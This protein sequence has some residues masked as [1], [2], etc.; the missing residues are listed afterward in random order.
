MCPI[1][2]PS[3][4]LLTHVR[5]WGSPSLR[6]N[7]TRSGGHLLLLLLG[8][9]L[10]RLLIRVI[11]LLRLLRRVSAIVVVGVLV[12][13]DRLLLLLHLVRLLQGGRGTWGRCRLIIGRSVSD[14]S[15]QMRSA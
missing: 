12:P 3:A 13:S 8:I 11:L 15:Y 4:V 2:P 5:I 10:R 1:S 6:Y 7:H 9:L 14:T